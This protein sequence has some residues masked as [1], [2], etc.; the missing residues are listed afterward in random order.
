MEEL[1]GD[2]TVRR[3]PKIWTRR[4]NGRSAK[5]GMSERLRSRRR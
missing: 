1:H 3:C 5:D 2:P 4:K